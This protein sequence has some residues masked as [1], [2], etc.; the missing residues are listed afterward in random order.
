M[1]KIY[2]K[3][4]GS[5]NYLAHQG[6][7]R[8]V[9]KGG[10]PFIIEVQKAG[11]NGVLKRSYPKGGKFHIR[12]CFFFVEPTGFKHTGIFPEQAVNWD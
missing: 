6:R 2:F 10:M 9:E 4:T 8:I 1:G 7:K 11:D 3:K 5:S 12:G